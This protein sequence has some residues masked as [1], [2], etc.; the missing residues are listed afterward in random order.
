MSDIFKTTLEPSKEEIVAAWLPKQDW[1]GADASKTQIVTGYRFD[2]PA[3]EVGIQG[4]IV[5]GGDASVYHVPVTYRGAPLEGAEDFLMGTMEHGKL[6][7]RWVYDAIGDALFQQELANIIAQGGTESKEFVIDAEG[8]KTPRAPQSYIK[9]SGSKADTS[10]SMAGAQV[11]TEDGVSTAL[12]REAS[13]S[14]LR[15]INSHAVFTAEVE[16]LSCTWPEKPTPVVV[17]TLLL[18][19]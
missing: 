9:G 1:W 11:T 19:N 12:S 4:L 5:S 14:I 7:K 15:R 16:T 10:P 18:R 8:N 2:D 3:G 13:L 17:A 6:G